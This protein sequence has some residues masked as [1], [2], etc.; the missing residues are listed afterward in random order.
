ME[1]AGKFGYV[2]VWVS[3]HDWSRVIIPGDEPFRVQANT[4][5]RLAGHVTVSRLAGHLHGLL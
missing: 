4:G 2:S 3:W 5:G 1:G